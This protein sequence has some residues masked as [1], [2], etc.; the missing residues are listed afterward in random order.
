MIKLS[1][2]FSI[3]GAALAGLWLYGFLGFVDDV[4]S[5]REPSAPLGS[6]DAIVVLTGGSERVA[7][8]V[9]LLKSGVGKKLF[10]SGV[11]KNLTLDGLF[12][13]L[14]I[15]QDIRNCCIVLGHQ[16]GSTAGNAEETRVWLKDEGYAS[17]RLVT[18]NYHMP[19]SL[20]LFR[21]AMP[22]VIIEPYPVTPDNV[23]LDEWWLHPGTVELL[24]TEYGK[25][26]VARTG[27]WTQKAA[28]KEQPQPS[29]AP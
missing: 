4:V 23:K 24:A 13:P 12:R 11:H 26:L 21:A 29:P 5:L 7:T 1:L 17:V 9:E 14:S 25:Y 6:A 18:A 20:L 10:I 8:G 15:P 3:I 2:F 28:P 22:D 27:L 19:R 16:A